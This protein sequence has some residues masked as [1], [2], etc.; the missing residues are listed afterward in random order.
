MRNPLK[1]LSSGMEM[2]I[3]KESKGTDFLSLKIS[4]ISAGNI[5]VKMS[6]ALKYAGLGQ[7]KAIVGGVISGME[8]PSIVLME[9][10]KNR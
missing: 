10:S 3:L 5:V 4:G 1:N 7:H 6:D 2:K 9:I 8:F